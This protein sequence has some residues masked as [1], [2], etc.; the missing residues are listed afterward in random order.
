MKR[1]T[2]Y[3]IEPFSFALLALLI[4]YVINDHLPEGTRLLTFS[5]Q[6][7][8]AAATATKVPTQDGDDPILVTRPEGL[9]VV[10]RKG[11]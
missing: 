8:E 6:K 5:T 2:F 11:E 1:G 3:V 4:C 7:I 9:V 10:E